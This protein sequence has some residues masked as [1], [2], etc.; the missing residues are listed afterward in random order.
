MRWKAKVVVQKTIS[1]LP[2]AE[3]LNYLLQRKVSK[4]L[5]AGDDQTRLHFTE[6]VRHLARYQRHGE[7]A[8]HEL[9]VYEFGAGWDLIGPLAMWSLGVERQTIVDLDAHLR[10]ELV[11]HTLA[12]LRRLQPELE[13]IAG[14]PIRVPDDAPVTDVGQLAERFGI[15]YRAPFDA[16]DTGFADDCFDLITSTFTLE[17]IPSADIDAILCESA[18]LLAPDGVVSCSV[19]MADHYA[20]DDPRISVYN[21]LRYPDRVWRLINSSLHY[22]NRLRARDYLDKF[23]RAG[24]A[25]VESVPDRSRQAELDSVP[26]A[27]HFAER[28]TPDELADTAIG[29]A[30]LRA[31]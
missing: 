2:Q 31:A 29:V 27:P 13:Q 7:R 17:H 25:V 21:Y 4:S 22:Q 3:S 15:D 11:D 24:L 23:E 14:R 10:F 9:R 16:R 12:Q 1:V 20:F 8:V 26:L 30:A 5:P 6:A 18:R 28:Y 19:D